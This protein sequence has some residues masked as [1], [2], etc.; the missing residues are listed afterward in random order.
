M[1][2]STKGG[3]HETRQ[4]PPAPG[5]DWTQIHNNTIVDIHYPSGYSYQAI[6]DEKSADSKIVWV[7]SLNGH[8]R[9]MYCSWDGIELRTSG[10]MLSRESAE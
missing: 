5:Q 9:K 1:T 2:G 3:Q 4:E 6:V 7:I 10:H 8:G